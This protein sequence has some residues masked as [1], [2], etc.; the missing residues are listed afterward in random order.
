MRENLL[1]FLLFSLVLPFISLA[2]QASKIIYEDEEG[3][4]RY[5][6]DNENNYIPDF[7]YAGYK[8]GEDS[9]P[10]LPIVKTLSAIEGDNTNHIQTALDELAMLTPDEKGWRGALLLEA[11]AY[12]IHGT[13]VIRESGI[14]LRGVGAE[15]DVLSN[16]VLLGV[17]NLSEGRDIIQMGNAPNA[18]WNQA[19]PGTN[20]TIT[21]SFVPAG[22]RS[23]KVAAPELYRKGDNVI[24]RHPSTQEWLA[25]IN[26]GATASDDS[27][28]PNTIDIVY[29][30][31]I[32][33][34]DSEESKI[35]LDAPIY[36][37][38][39]RS[40]SQTLIYTLDKTNI[41]QNIGVENL[42]ID[43]QTDGP[44]TENH[45]RNAIKLIGVEDCW[46]RKVTALHFIYA[47][48]DTRSASRVT[49][50]D[51]QGLEPHSEITGARRYN[52]A[53]GRESN[54]ILFVNCR[55]T[56]GRHSFVSNGISSVS[57]IVFYNCTSEVDY[58]PSE[59]HRRWSQ[60][61]LFDNITFTK[62]ETSTLIGLYNRGDYGTGH[63]WSTTNG[64][65][66]KVSVPNSKKII[67]Q[68]P[69]GRQNY[70]IACQALVTN[71]HRFPHP[72]GYAELDNQVPL[73]P[74]LYLKQLENR[75]QLGIP[76]DAPAKLDANFVNG[77]VL[78]NWIDIAS[79][80]SGYIVELSVDGGDHFS[81]IA[82][83]PADET[84]FLHT[85]L[86]GVDEQLIYRVFA[87]GNQCPSPYSNEVK[88]SLITSTQSTPI[89]RLNVFPNPFSDSIQIQAG[90]QINLI[91]VFDSLGKELM[92]TESIATL[93]A[94]TLLKGIY[95]LQ[96]TD[97]QGRVNLVKVA[98]Q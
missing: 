98:K 70:A 58:G 87:L 4:L 96:I 54:Q 56:E 30:R 97:D 18:N 2:Q 8:N 75:L 26:F 49:V 66:W 41:K 25:S 11:G 71:T 52:F 19:I 7:S 42:R 15:K 93:N 17:G 65:A 22:S 44:L 74:S 81:E 28:T 33:E 37:H 59:G 76:P 12:E 13:V 60:G 91:K 29:N 36:D 88:A 6:A 38:F 69:P 64:V 39:D 31:Y 90:T 47:A 55:A 80:E 83:L 85:G 1:F 95:Y 92:K 79:Q 94:S 73:I 5:V 45:A 32:M 46:V 62:S 40:L 16:T 27:W 34:V 43:I 53:V 57:G 72:P 9:I 48:V 78:L 67:L 14:V 89:P 10:L 21:S 23:L 20:S 77:M 3:C 61:M 63:G 82:Q 84:S 35:T 24:L 50:K 51:C 86:S 68:K